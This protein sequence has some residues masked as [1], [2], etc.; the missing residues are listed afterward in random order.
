MRAQVAT[1]S[2]IAI[3]GLSLG[4]DDEPLA[5]VTGDGSVSEGGGLECRFTPKLVRD[6][7]KVL[8]ALEEVEETD[9]LVFRRSRM[10]ANACISCGR[11]SQLVVR[12]WV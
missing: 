9:K 1:H 2:R 12:L 4:L 8:E 7:P 10:I 3:P 5:P 6:D 11:L